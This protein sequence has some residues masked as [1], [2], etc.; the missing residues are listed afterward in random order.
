MTEF[1]K[2]YDDLLADHYTWMAGGLEAQ[3]EKNTGFFESH[4]I[5]PR[6]SGLAIDLGAGS[7]FQSIPLARAGFKVVAVD[8]CE[9]LLEELRE[10][11]QGL[12][13]DILRDNILNLSGFG[14]EKAELITCM[15]DTLTHLDDQAAVNNLFKTAHAKLEEGGR[16]VLTYRDLSAELK[17]EARFIHVNSEAERIFT[18]FLEY[19]EK[20]VIVHDLV[21][22][23][24]EE[25]W[26]LLKGSYPK[27]R[28]AAERVL[29]S[30][31]VAGF[32]VEHHSESRGLHTIIAQRTGK[33]FFR[34][35]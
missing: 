11:S 2:H 21:Y 14:P 6:L 31:E 35:D 23:K 22:I 15:G 16:L 3:I 19:E 26:R 1:A 8:L 12:D 5:R 9:K 17:G 7:G 30:L 18:C 33:P 13:I 4:G 24:K 34:Q 32:S 25:G 27:L 20:H 28:L 10:N 29:G